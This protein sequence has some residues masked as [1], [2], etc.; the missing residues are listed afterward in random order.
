MA[1]ARHHM[2]GIHLLLKTFS[3]GD[4]DIRLKESD[5]RKSNASEESKF[6]HIWVDILE[7]ASGYQL[8]EVYL[9][10]DLFG[11]MSHVLETHILP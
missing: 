8:F 2:P 3:F 11:H 1:M 7:I 10:F 4:Q 6:T 9:M 5:R